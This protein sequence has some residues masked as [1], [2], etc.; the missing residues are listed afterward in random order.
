MDAGGFYAP[1]PYS[2]SIPPG[3]SPLP[4]YAPYADAS[5]ALNQKLDQLVTLVQAQSQETAAIRNEL[6]AVKSEVASLNEA[7]YSANSSKSAHSRQKIPREL[8]LGA[9]N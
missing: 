8:W 4:P 7:A 2:S 3:E 9:N 6:S 5:L 1:L